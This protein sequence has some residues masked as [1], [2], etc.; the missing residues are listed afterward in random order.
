M[1][2]MHAATS[3]VLTLAIAG[4]CCLATTVATAAPGG[5]LA[6]RRDLSPVDRAKVL[7]VQSKRWLGYGSTGQT[8]DT[9][10]TP[11]M[12]GS[13]VCQTNI[14][15]P[16]ANPNQGAGQYGPQGGRYGPGSTGDNIVV[17][18]GDVINACK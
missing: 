5:E 14:G 1:K 11:G 6:Q 13:R 12:V 4:V 9:T 17:V 8:T 18:S 16:A 7:R 15:V 10:S 3:S 2:I